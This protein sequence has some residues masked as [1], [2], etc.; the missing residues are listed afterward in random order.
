MEV[1]AKLLAKWKR[2]RSRMRDWRLMIE[3][4]GVSEEKLGT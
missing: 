3:A 1:A 4:E 2:N